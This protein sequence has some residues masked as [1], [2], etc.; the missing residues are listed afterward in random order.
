MSIPSV[1][2]NRLRRIEQRDCNASEL[3]AWYKQILEWIIYETSRE[4]G[5]QLAAM[6]CLERL[7]V[8]AYNLWA[9][10]HMQG[11]Y[12]AAIANANRELVSQMVSNRE[13]MPTDVVNGL[14]I[15][16]AMYNANAATTSGTGLRAALTNATTA[17][18][19]VY[20][21]NHLE[22]HAL[23]RTC[24]VEGDKLVIGSLNSGH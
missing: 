3:E 16:G 15:I 23:D 11:P 17:V 1:F 13:S 4:G 7:R 21:A 6:Q 10:A 9:N 18:N 24:A 19:N 12:E 5:D 8:A 14:N 2:N 20:G 22:V